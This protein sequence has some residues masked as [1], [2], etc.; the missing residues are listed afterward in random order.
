MSFLRLLLIVIEMACTTKQ[1]SIPLMEASDLAEHKK[2]SKSVKIDVY[3]EESR[4][5]RKYLAQQEAFR[6]LEQRKT[7]ALAAAHRVSFIR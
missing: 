1:Q 7:Y 5:Y 2:T 4:K 3:D 6:Q